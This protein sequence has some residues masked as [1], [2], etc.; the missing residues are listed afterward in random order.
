MRFSDIKVRHVYNVIFD[1]AR[2]CEFDGKHLALVLKENNDKN[3][4]IV[5]PLTSQPNGDGVNKIRLSNINGLPSSLKNNDTYA[6]YNQVRTV[7]ADRFIAL[8]DGGLRVQ[9][10]LEDEIYFDLLKLAIVDMLH[11][12]NQDLKIEIME[13]I[14]N[15]P[16]NLEQKYVDD[17]IQD[18]FIESLA[19]SQN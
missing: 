8:K 7:N 14:K 15:I 10:K 3:T 6:V 19:Q 9:V 1:P 5:M 16:Y 12:C 2:H 4:F 17:G 11:N 18:I 13:T